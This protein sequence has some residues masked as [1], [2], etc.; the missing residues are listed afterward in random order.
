M[1]PKNLKYQSKVESAASRSSR[2]NIAP[3]NGTGPYSLG[4]TLIFNFPTHGK[5]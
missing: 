5:I 4:D 3:N 1:L 2:I